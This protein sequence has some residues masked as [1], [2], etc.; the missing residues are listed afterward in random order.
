MGYYQPRETIAVT[1]SSV[2]GVRSDS[3]SVQ[4]APAG[5]L[6]TFFVATFT[7]T[8][9]CWISIVA[10]HISEH[11][12]ARAVL[13]LLGTFAPALVALGVVAKNDGRAGIQDLIRRLWQWHVGA[14]WYLLAVSYMAVVKLT[15][16]LAHRL[17]AHSWPQFGK[18]PWY[19]LV[20]AVIFSTPVQSGEE[21]GWR[22]FALP[23]LAERMG[24]GRASLVLGLIWAT[25]HLPIFF[26]P[27]ADKYGQ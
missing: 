24:Y 2:S 5:P 15:A 27:G 18:D 17:I 8:W 22:G 16:A 14:R 19:L 20:I 6:L 25:W 13:E 10:A 3:T 23:R 11:A 12:P 21:I 26:I 4:S 7:V 9:I 1:T